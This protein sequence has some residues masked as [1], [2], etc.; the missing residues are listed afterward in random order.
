MPTP[1]VKILGVLL[2]QK[3][4]FES[5]VGKTASKG[6]MAVLALRRLR[7]LPPAVAR[8]LFMSTLRL[9][10]IKLRLCGALPERILLF[11]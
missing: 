2:D 6:M 3:L 5:H 9:R 10:S 7:G 1:E 11:P 4:R 8:Q